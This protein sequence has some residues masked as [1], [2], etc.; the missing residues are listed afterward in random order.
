[1]IKVQ[2]LCALGWTYTL[3]RI[4]KSDAIVKGVESD[5]I[6]TVDHTIPSEHIVRL[7]QEFVDNAHFTK[8]A[9]EAREYYQRISAAET[10]L[11]MDETDVDILRSIRWLHG[12]LFKFHKFPILRHFILEHCG[13]ALY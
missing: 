2:L 1:M 6:A 11:A 13:N 9:I 7:A 4:L 8:D 3:A 12:H 10:K 5:T